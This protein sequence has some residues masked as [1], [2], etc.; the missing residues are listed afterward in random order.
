MDAGE[1]A[2]L[3]WMV[4][5]PH[6]WLTTHDK[7]ALRRL[8]A[9]PALGQMRAA[10]AG[11][12][13]CLETVLLG[14]VER[15]GAAQALTPM[16][17]T[18]TVLRAVFTPGNVARAGECSQGLRFYEQQLAREVGAALLWQPGP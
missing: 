11:R 13:I 7:R 16:L 9:T 2:L 17:P 14:L 1:A 4:Q 5:E 15:V 18:S 6:Y 12:V 8:A 10:I 3:A